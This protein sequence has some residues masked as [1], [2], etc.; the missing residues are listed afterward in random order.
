MISK[1]NPD[2]TRWDINK[3][4]KHVQKNKLQQPPES[5]QERYLLNEKYP[6]IFLTLREVQCL[7]L[8]LD[9]LS[10]KEIGKI[11]NISHR[12]VETYFEKIRHK[13]DCNR[14]H[15]LPYKVLIDTEE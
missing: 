10:A 14:L 11:L 6:N 4:L 8:Y 13:L 5:I 7:V 1:D 3:L 15:D 12:T 9:G 2:T